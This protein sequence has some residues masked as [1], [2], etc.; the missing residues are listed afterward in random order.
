MTPATAFVPMAV[1]L[2]GAAAVWSSATIAL[3][4]RPWSIA[5]VM[6]LGVLAVAADV[7]RR[8]RRLPDVLVALAATPLVVVVIVALATGSSEVA[9]A[10]GVGAMAAAAPIAVLHLASPSSM[11][12]GDVK[13][14]AVLGGAVGVVEWR[15]ALVTVCAAAAAAGASALLGR[16]HTLAFGPFL[17]GAALVV[18]AGAA[19]AGPEAVR[20]R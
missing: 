16:R 3:A 17:V 6:A 12:F 14:A 1:A 20:W 8:E 11:G 7:D 4:H 2:V 5:T 15:L 18:V 19:L 10:I 9:G 13:A